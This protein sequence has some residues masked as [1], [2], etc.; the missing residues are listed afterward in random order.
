MPSQVKRTTQ[1]SGGVLSE[2]TNTLGCIHPG[3]GAACTVVAGRRYF[4]FVSQTEESGNDLNGAALPTVTSTYSGY[5]LYG[6]VG[7]VTV[8]TGDGYSKVTT[9]T[10]TNDVTNWFLGRL[11]RSTVLSTIP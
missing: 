7:T 5:D 10:Y 8:S 9:N 11:T 2:V 6:N 3:A 1:S 4:P